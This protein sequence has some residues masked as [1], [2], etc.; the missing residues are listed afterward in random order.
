MPSIG[1]PFPASRSGD[2]E[3]LEH[4][5]RRAGDRRGAAV[6][7]GGENRLGVG[8]IDH[9]RAQPVRV[10]RDRKRTANQPAAEDEDVRL[11]H[12]RGVAELRRGASLDAGLVQ[13]R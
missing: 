11:I 6:E 12:E 3:R 1:Q 10:E 8:R 13:A 4:P 7:C 2:A 9:D 5:P